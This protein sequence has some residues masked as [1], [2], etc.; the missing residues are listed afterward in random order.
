MCPYSSTAFCSQLC[1]ALP[2]D[3]P[4]PDSSSGSLLPVPVEPLA[5]GCVPSKTLV[6]L[7]NL[8]KAAAALQ[9]LTNK[10]LLSVP[11]MCGCLLSVL[12]LQ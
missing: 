2:Q 9:T 8:S 7:S 11:D 12:T 6:L 1:A 3:V 5:V 10:C 4:T